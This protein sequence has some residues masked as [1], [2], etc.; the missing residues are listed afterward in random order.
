MRSRVAPSV[1]GLG[2][3]A[4]VPR[5]E[6]CGAHEFVRRTRVCTAHTSLYGAHEFVRAAGSA[7]YERRRWTALAC[8]LVREG[9]A[10]RWLSSR[11]RPCPMGRTVRCPRVHAPTSPDAQPEGALPRSPGTSRHALPPLRSAHSRRTLSPGR[12]V[13]RRPAHR[14]PVHRHSVRHRP[15]HRRAVRSR[16]VRGRTVDRRPVRRGPVRRGPVRP[17][18][19]PCRRVCRGPVQHQPVARVP[20]ARLRVRRWRVRCRLVRGR[21]GRRRGVW[22]RVVVLVVVLVVVAAGLG[23]GVGRPSG[24]GLRGL[25]RW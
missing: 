21:A 7:A 16:H 18:P 23:G 20:V 3:G 14:C 22:R 5:H 13:R 24:G 10:R 4:H 11:R 19:V 9:Q 25:V 15:A 6:Q 17:Q 1:R 2:R 12:L 8:G